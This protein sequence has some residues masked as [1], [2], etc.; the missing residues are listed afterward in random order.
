MGHGTHTH[1]KHT[2]SLHSNSVWRHLLHGHMWTR[3]CSTEGTAV[4]DHH[5]ITGKEGQ[6]KSSAVNWKN[7]TDGVQS[8]S[9]QQSGL[10]CPDQ[11]GSMI[12]QEGHIDVHSYH[13]QVEVERT[14]VHLLER[15]PLLGWNLLPH[16]YGSPS[17]VPQRRCSRGCWAKC[18]A[19]NTQC[20]TT[21]ARVKWTEDNLTCVGPVECLQVLVVYQPVLS[22]HL[23]GPLSF[24]KSLEVH[25]VFTSIRGCRWDRSKAASDLTGLIILFRRSGLLKWPWC[26]LSWA[27]I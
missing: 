27:T 17:K 10:R 9:G 23:I 5:R 12:W 1:T 8:V 14:D 15:A 18:S 4:G 25:G 7:Q 20:H 24:W 2:C 21:N 13:L 3:P 6:N 26:T 22:F 16:P 11:S 19:S